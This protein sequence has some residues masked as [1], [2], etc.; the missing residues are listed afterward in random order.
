MADEHPLG[1]EDRVLVLAPTARDGAT[2]RDLLAAAGVRCH[3]CAS[4][5]E[6]CRE[7]ARGAGA[8]VVTAEAVLGD[9]GGQLVRVLQAQP[10]WS[11]FPLVVLTR[12]GAESPALLRALEATGHMTLVQRPVQVSVLVSAAR[13]ALRD[14]RRQY[15]M[16]DLT[17]G[18]ERQ[19]AERTAALLQ[20]ERLAAI[21]QTA[22]TLAHEG[23]NALQRAHSCLAML[24]YYAAGRPAELDL[25][26]RGRRALADLGRLFEDLRD[27]AAPVRLDVR[28]CDLGQ[29]WREA[30]AQVTAARPRPDAR[31]DESPGETDLAVE[32]DPFRLGQMFTN[33]FANALE[34]CPDPVRIVVEAGEASVGGRPGV[35]VAVRDN[36]PGFNP[37]QRQKALDPFFTTKSTGTGL[38]LA[39][40]R[41]LVEAHGGVLTIGEQAA[42]GATMVVVLPRRYKSGTGTS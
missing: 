20:A 14:R 34:A 33:L 27:Y 5:D 36:G 10:P 13:G 41:R 23:R 37:E 32:A 39:I 1:G 21:G 38:G 42:T 22:A 7:I 17:A 2:S 40:T 15:A 35:R 28:P 3:V 30:W 11:D 9:R 31:L 16:R 18:L 8:A 6:V 19:V 26:A 4:L 24:E 12:A 29:V 25:V